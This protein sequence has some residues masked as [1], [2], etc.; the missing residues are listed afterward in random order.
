MLGKLGRCLRFGTVQEDGYGVSGQKSQ[1]GRRA[2]PFHYLDGS[3]LIGCL[4]SAGGCGAWED[5]RRVFITH[6]H[7]KNDNL[8]PFR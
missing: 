8:V 7:S 4:D 2:A 6:A 1:G 5:E 3:Y